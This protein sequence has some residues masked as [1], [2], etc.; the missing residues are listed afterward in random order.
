[1]TAKASGSAKAAAQGQHKKVNQKETQ[2]QS[3]F[4][5]STDSPPSQKTSPTSTTSST[6]QT[7]YQDQDSL[8]THKVIMAD[9]GISLAKLLIVLAMFPVIFGGLAK[10]G[11]SWK[12]ILGGG[13]CFLATVTVSTFFLMKKSLIAPGSDRRLTLPS[14]A[15]CTSIAATS[16]SFPP[17]PPRRRRPLPLPPTS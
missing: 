5:C 7:T 12:A 10:L 8:T 16:S 1:M 13:A 4:S 6:S 9:R 15:F 2:L 11:A 14:C 17:V 3:S